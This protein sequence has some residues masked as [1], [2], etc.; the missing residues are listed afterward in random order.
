MSKG[1]FWL[2]GVLVFCCNCSNVYGQGSFFSAADA[3]KTK[4]SNTERKIIP[5]K[6]FTSSLNVASLKNFLMSLP[7][8]K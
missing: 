2:I 7:G 3:E 1:K 4:L 8:E 6:Y 5:G